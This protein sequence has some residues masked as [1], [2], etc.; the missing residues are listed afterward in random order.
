MCKKTIGII[1]GMGPMATVDLFRKLVEHTVAESDAGHIHILIDN[2][3]QI[4][5]R[6]KAILT[7]DN[8]VADYLAESAQRLVNA[9]ADFLIIPCNTSHCFYDI[10][11]SRIQ[12]PVIHM[13]RACAQKVKSLGYEKVA[14]LATDGTVHSGIYPSVFAEYGIEVLLPSAQ[15]QK[16]VMQLIYDE[17]KAG[18]E[19]H[20]QILDAERKALQDRGAQ[21]FILGCTELPLAFPADSSGMFIDPTAILAETAIKAA[22][23]QYKA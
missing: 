12:V 13:I 17:I 11:C 18:K 4:P 9:G 3:P 8:S 21:A 23:Y 10:L 14:L 16:K 19:V 2:Y 5:D 15:G 7:G 20:P 6:T 22:G 1:G